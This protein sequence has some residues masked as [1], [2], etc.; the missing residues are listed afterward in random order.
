MKAEIISIGDE[1][2]SGLV[3]NSNAVFISEKLFSIGIE[4]RKVLTIGDNNEEIV[5]SLNSLSK[6]SSIV[7]ITG[8]LGPT[9][10]DITRFAISEKFNQELVFNEKAF[11]HY[12]AFYKKKNLKYAM[13]N[14]VQA[15][16]PDGF[17]V[18][19]N[20]LGTALGMYF[21]DKNKCYFILPGVPAEM[22]NMIKIFVIPLLKKKN[23]YIYFF[24]KII[25]TF[26]ISESKLFEII[27]TFNIE[28]VKV[29]YLPQSPGVDLKLFSSGNN[30]EKNI[31]KVINIKNAISK[32]IT[33]HIYGYDELTLVEA[34]AEILIKNNLT[35]SV[36]ESCTG[37]LISDMITNISGCS[38]YFKKSI[39]TYSNES[40]IS[41]IGVSKK[42][43]E[44]YGAVSKEVAIEMV[45][46]VSKNVNIGLATTG[47][48]G[49]TGGSIDKPVGL[50]FVGLVINDII[51]VKKIISVGN[52]L[53]NKHWF[54][55]N[56]L[57]FLFKNLRALE[58]KVEN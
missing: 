42:T 50:L 6:D 33:E 47:I 30:K 4:V 26:G 11:S 52:R 14:K 57:Y 44:K 20:P 49:P 48:A 35:I 54:A 12:K 10:D 31:E 46:G 18:I 37:G 28:N 36:A 41:L 38:L 29:A 15:M 40:K 32:K 1:L 45:K 39:V 7:I 58:K 19:D 3:V 22:E 53:K 51:K 2:L 34:I 56:A 55:M 43:L 17:K 5:E 25:R 24:Q 13:S 9:D 27:K 23:K 21:Q 16:I 8:G